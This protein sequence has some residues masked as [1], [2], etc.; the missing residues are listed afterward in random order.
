MKQILNI[1]SF[2][3]QTASTVPLDQ[4]LF[5]P[6]PQVLRFQ[7]YEEFQ[8][9]TK[10]LRFRNSDTVARRFKILP[11]D[12]SHFKVDGP[13]GVDGSVLPDT[14]IAPGIEV[15]FKVTF[16]PQKRREYLYDLVCV[17]EREKFIVPLR[18]TGPRAFV[19]F[20]DIIS[21]GVGPCKKRID[22][23]IMVRWL[24]PHQ[25]FAQVTSLIIACTFDFRSRIVAR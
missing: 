19:N 12:S 25:D 11:P 16:F 1:A 4:P 17:T 20:P 22:K 8:Q 3:H 2:S 23:P 7:D 14:R 21:F 18:A 6:S 10:P 5:A 9:R 15:V 24:S 13:F